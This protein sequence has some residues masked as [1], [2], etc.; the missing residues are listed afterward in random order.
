MDSIPEGKRR[1]IRQPTER[2]IEMDTYYEKV[3]VGLENSADELRSYVEELEEK[4]SG[5]ESDVEERD[6][7]ISDLQDRITELESELENHDN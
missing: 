6:T 3:F 5:L 7:A 4:V 1:H 2:E